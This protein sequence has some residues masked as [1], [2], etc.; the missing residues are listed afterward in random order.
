MIGFSYK[1]LGHR[2]RLE[3]RVRFAD[4]FDQRLAAIDPGAERAK[5]A[6]K[7]RGKVWATATTNNA[8]CD[9]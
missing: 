7:A 3:N 1:P 4:C 9:V 5:A 8:G 2:A 6:L